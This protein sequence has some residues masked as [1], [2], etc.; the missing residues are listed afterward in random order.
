[1]PWRAP[2]TH[3]IAYATRGF[4]ESG[5]LLG[6]ARYVD[7]AL[8]AGRGLAAVQR[9]DGWLAGTYKDGWVTDAGYSCLTGVAQM[10]LN[11]TRLAQVT[12]DETLRKNA[13]AAL[14]YL[15]TTQRLDDEDPAIRG[16]IAGSAPIWGDYS[17]FEYPN[18]AAKFFA[19]ALMM[20]MADI[21]VPP[22]PD[23][24][25]GMRHG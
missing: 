25:R 24:A 18:W 9:Q 23:I 17:R 16:G 20:D 2:F 13:R 11:W 19:D 10:S 4:L 6:E 12:G 3:T 14:A 5:V 15:K 22:V 7:A 8:K 1:M 21:A